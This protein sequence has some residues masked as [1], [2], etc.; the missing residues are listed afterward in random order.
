MDR[1]YNIESTR[2]VASLET[3][4][5]LKTVEDYKLRLWLDRC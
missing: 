2:Y 4:R 5:H 1:C 3:F